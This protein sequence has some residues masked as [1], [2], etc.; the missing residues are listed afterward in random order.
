LQR[1]TNTPTKFSGVAE[2][3]RNVNGILYTKRTSEKRKR[4]ND[5]FIKY[6]IFCRF[7]LAEH[8]FWS[9]I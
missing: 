2:R 3:E 8:L 1:L 5:K 7:I 4:T 6:I 9:T